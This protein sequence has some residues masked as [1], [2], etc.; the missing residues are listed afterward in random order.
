MDGTLIAA[1]LTGNGQLETQEEWRWPMNNLQSAIWASATVISIAVVGS[2]VIAVWGGDHATATI[3]L[4]V[5]LIGPTI[6]AIFAAVK[7]QEA[8]SKASEAKHAI[9]SVAQAV[10][11][12][13]AVM[14]EVMNNQ[15]VATREALANQGDSM[16]EAV[17]D[18][19]SHAV[20]EIKRAVKNG[21]D[22]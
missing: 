12:Q 3:P 10:T 17:K 4:I 11:N 1:R 7:A 5:G 8:A 15:S 20:E 22:G 6:P 2:V 18:A 19:A 14:R 9:P 13:G 21:H 16:R